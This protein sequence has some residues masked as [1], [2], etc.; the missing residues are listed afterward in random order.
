MVE[1]I[2]IVLDAILITGMVMAGVVLVNAVK[3]LIRAY[4]LTR[5]NK[6]EPDKAD[7]EIFYRKSEVR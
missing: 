5:A 1:I 3:K 6:I 4:K 7:K 2:V